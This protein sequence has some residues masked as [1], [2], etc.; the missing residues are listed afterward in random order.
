MLNTSE[1]QLSHAHDVTAAG[2]AALS[3]QIVLQSVFQFVGPRQFLIMAAVSRFWRQQYLMVPVEGTY[4]RF[5]FYEA[6]KHTRR[7]CV[8][9]KGSGCTAY[10]AV[11]ASAQ[12][13]HMAY[14]SGLLDL[15]SSLLQ[16]SAGQHASEAVMQVAYELG[17]PCTAAVVRG[18]AAAGSVSKLQ[19]AY[20]MNSNSSM[21]TDLT[22]SAASSGS[23]QVLAWSEQLKHCIDVETSEYAAKA[24]HM[25]VLYYLHFQGC[26]MD[27]SSIART[28]AVR[29]NTDVFRFLHEFGRYTRSIGQAVL[30]QA[31][32]SGSVELMQWLVQH[33]VQLNASAMRL[34]VYCGHLD[35]CKYLQS[36]GCSWSAE[37]TVAA[38]AHNRADIVSWAVA[39][40]LAELT[41]EQQS[42]LDKRS[43]S[44]SLGCTVDNNFTLKKLY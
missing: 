22:H 44:S 25:P 43:A 41:V 6:A 36:Q 13:L 19:I 30:E 10:S 27:A 24:G 7:T 39:A 3:K 21:L 16:Y 40:G 38:I 32:G 4:N 42:R 8:R 9:H 29:G 23:V 35:M 20:T 18:C 31:A 33:D 26:S 11:F 15:H 5:S 34:A 1:A 2:G 14:E 37:L 28:A 12:L 17:M